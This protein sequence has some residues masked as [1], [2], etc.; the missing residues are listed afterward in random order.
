MQS[1]QLS[2]V[3]ILLPA[4][5]LACG[6]E[7]WPVKVASDQNAGLIKAKPIDTTIRYLVGLPAPPHPDQLRNGR[8]QGETSIFR[9]RNVQIV[10]ARHER[11]GDYHLVLRPLRL[12]YDSRLRMI[13]EA[14]DSRCAQ[15]SRFLS[16]IRQVHRQVRRLIRDLP[17]RVMMT[18]VAFFDVLHRQHGVAPNGIEL[19]PIL[20]IQV[21][22]PGA[23]TDR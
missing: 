12:S 2:I 16:R 1:L 13:A 4:M 9:L 22:H 14:P 17:I 23:G 10:W 5:A 20:S 3:L 8:W 18:G 6:R 7:R 15:G 11:D 19:H 21:P